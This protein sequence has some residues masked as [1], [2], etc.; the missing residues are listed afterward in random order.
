MATNEGVWS[1]WN[2]FYGS[3]DYAIT[4]DVLNISTAA[5]NQSSMLYLSRVVKPG[6]R[7]TVEFEARAIAGVG[8]ITAS[9]RVAYT[10]YNTAKVS[11]HSDFRTYRFEFEAPTKQVGPALAY[12]GLGIWRA[13]NVSSAA[14]LEFVMRSIRSNDSGGRNLLHPDTFGLLQPETRLLLGNLLIEPYKG[15]TNLIDDVVYQLKQAGI[16]AKLDALYVLAEPYQELA[17]INWI[18]PG[19]YDLKEVNS[20]TFAADVGYSGRV[21]AVTPPYLQ[22]GFNP[23]ALAGTDDDGNGIADEAWAAKF[24]G[25]NNSMFVWADYV[26]GVPNYIIGTRA[27]AI[28]PFSETYADRVYCRNGVES[29]SYVAGVSRVSGLY[30]MSRDNSST[31]DIYVNG[32][33]AGTVTSTPTTMYSESIQILKRSAN[34]GTANNNPVRIAGFG[35]SLTALEWADLYRVFAAYL[36]AVDS[37]AAEL[38]ASYTWLTKPAA[39]LYPGSE[40]TISDVGVAGSRWRSDGVRWINMHPVVLGRLGAPVTRNASTSTAES[41]AVYALAIPGGIMGVNSLIQILPL[42]T[43]NNSATNKTLRVKSAGNSIGTF[44]LTTVV[45]EQPIIMFQNINSLAAQKTFTGNASAIGSISTDPAGTNVDTTVDWSLTATLQAEN[46]LN[47]DT[48]TLESVTVV[49]F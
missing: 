30:G 27:H 9:S 24:T 4:D 44:I 23:L 21:D 10:A 49:L 16:W 31:F 47:N 41:G 14:E 3:G 11:G 17:L 29:G 34:T 20:P 12:I 8:R 40:I 22:T 26:E 2:Y 33:S 37:S 35:E 45:A 1:G 7:I 43:C 6:E 18:N 46:V 38:D 13:D 36:N 39:A 28:N 25:N 15:R 48:I 5:G 42:A 32:A 19:Q